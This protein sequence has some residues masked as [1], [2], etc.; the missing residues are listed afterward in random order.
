MVDP[1]DNDIED[2]DTKLLDPVP[3]D[4]DPALPMLLEPLAMFN[5]PLEDTD[6]DPE[7][8]DTGPDPSVELDIDTEPPLPLRN[9][10]KP[11][12]DLS[13]ELIPPN[14]DIDP[15]E[16]PEPDDKLIDPPTPELCTDDTPATREMSP[17][18]N[19]EPLTSWRL[20]TSPETIDTDPLGLALE[21]P[22]EITIEP[23]PWLP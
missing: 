8:M 17:A 14:N 21:A 10:T 12:S 20:S 5:L 23:D 7:F 2:P 16:N 11:P 6:D 15:P 9:S 13:D 22:E 4:I 1:A 19:N 3:S 18:L